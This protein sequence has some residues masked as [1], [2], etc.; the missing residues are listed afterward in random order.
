MK[1]L[2]C[3]FLIFSLLLC[4]CSSLGERI[5][6]PTTFYYLC[7]QYQQDLCCVILTEER[8]ASGHTD[9]LSYLLALYLMGPVSEECRSPLPSGTAVQSIQHNSNTL[10]I[11]LSDLDKT[12]SDSEFSLAGACLTMTCLDIVPA[13]NVTVISGTRSVTMNRNSLSLFDS[14]VED[15][16]KETTK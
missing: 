14:S 6:E 3:L 4:G 1:Q 2:I 16:P 8:E 5:K 13:R 10:T 15:A 11:E 9:D 12:L 7:G